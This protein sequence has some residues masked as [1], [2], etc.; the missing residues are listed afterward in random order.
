MK[1]KILMGMIKE[2]L[3]ELSANGVAK[4]RP[5]GGSMAGRID[6]GQLVTLVTVNPHELEVGDIA[7]VRWKKRYILHLI[8]DMNED[9]F[10]MGNNLGRINGWVAKNDAIARVDKIEN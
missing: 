10:L 8:V 6:S 5:E 1:L 2:L 4:I 9:Q 3:K 7:L